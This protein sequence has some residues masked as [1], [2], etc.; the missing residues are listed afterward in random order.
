[1][2]VETLKT[3]YSP[4]SSVKEILKILNNSRYITEIRKAPEIPL[5]FNTGFR[6]STHLGTPMDLYFDL[7]YHEV[8]RT[9]ES[10][11]EL[12]PPHLIG[13]IGT[14]KNTQYIDQVIEV[15][16]IHMD[17]AEVALA[18]SESLLRGLGIVDYF[19]ADKVIAEGSC[20]STIEIINGIGEKKDHTFFQLIEGNK[21]TQL[22]LRKTLDEPVFFDG[23][24]FSE[25]NLG[26][27][28]NDEDEED[29][30]YNSDDNNGAHW[31]CDACGGDS[32]TGCMSST[33]ECYK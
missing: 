18:N 1:M 24:R 6:F 20:L 30:R 2:L 29:Y 14:I 12:K 10:P 32:N 28:E 26:H 3:L 22:P 16:C 5:L 9:R 8:I 25:Y 4:N 21:I 23:T 33:G 15:F 7:N 11:Y 27:F 19:N 31:S 17:K 13:F